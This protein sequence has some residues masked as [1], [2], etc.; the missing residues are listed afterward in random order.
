MA[1]KLYEYSGGKTAG[2]TRDSFLRTVRGGLIRI[3]VTNPNVTPGSDYYILGQA[4]GNE[5]EPL[6]ANNVLAFDDTMPSTATGQKLIDWLDIYGLSLRDAGPSI[7]NVTLESTAASTVTTGQELIDEAGLRFSVVTGGI[8]NDGDTIQVQGIDTGDATNHAAGDVLRWVSAPPFAS[9]IAEVAAGGLVN[10]VD[11]ESEEAGRARLIERLTSPPASG[12]WSHVTT[13]TEEAHPSV[14]KAFCYPAV[15]GPG[16]FHSAAVAEPTATSK[17]RVVSSTTI[18][19]VVSPYVQ[20]KYPEH[21]YSIITSVVDVDTYLSIGLTLPEAPSA[22]I[23]GP[24]GGWLNGSPWPVPNPMSNACALTAVA[25][26]T[27]FTLNAETAP[28]AG[29]SA[30]SWLSSI[31]WKLYSAKVVS[32]TG[33]NPYTVTLDVPFTGIVVGDYVWPSF[34][35]QEEVVAAVL[36]AYSLMGPGEKTDNASSLVRGFRHPRTAESWPS[37]LGAHLLR[38]VSNAS[39]TI[40]DATFLYR[41]DGTTSTTSAG[42]VISPEVLDP[43]NVEDP[44]NIFVPYRLAF[45]RIT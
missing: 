30:I 32:F 3:G 24:G 2:E 7:G 19:T 23:P 10:G 26:S 17:S 41:S 40:E 38:A 1:K 31:D 12:N 34:E 36:E 37:T 43:T 14:Q 5:L 11:A 15:Q 45:H 39:D 28:V 8:Y 25:S 44:P 4:L 22:S 6:A 16:T 21:A 29:V 42:G 33:T 35:T 9:D 20:G 18:S 13:T 27:E